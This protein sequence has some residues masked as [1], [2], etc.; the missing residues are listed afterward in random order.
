MY[1]C[2]N[3]HI[4]LLFFKTLIMA[5]FM[6]SFFFYQIAL[7]PNNLFCLLAEMMKSFEVICPVLGDLG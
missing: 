5:N 6:L 3:L 7:K 4:F 1:L 2:Q